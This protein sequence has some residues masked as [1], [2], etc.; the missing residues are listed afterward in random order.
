MKFFHPL[1]I[2]SF[3]L[4]SVVLTSCDKTN[5]L[6]QREKILEDVA[7]IKRTLSTDDSLKIYFL[8]K[9]CDYSGGFDRLIEIENKRENNYVLKEYLNKEA[10]QKSTDSLFREAK[11]EGFTYRDLLIEIDTLIKVK[12]QYEDEYQV[13]YKKIDSICLQVQKIIDVKETL[14]AK[15]SDSIKKSISLKLLSIGKNEYSDDIEV[16]ILIK[17]QFQKPINALSFD[18][19]LTDK[20]GATVAILSC[21][22]NETVIKN[23]VGTWSFEKYGDDRETYNGLENVEAHHVTVNYTITKVNIGGKIIGVDNPLLNL[24]ENL[25]YHYNAKYIS[26]KNLIGHC[27]Y[28]N[29]DHP[30][31]LELKKLNDK[32]SKVRD[33]KKLPIVDLIGQLTIY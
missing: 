8:D 14:N 26:K 4:L 18:A 29:K 21:K 9:L 11:R 16:K 17:N 3:F 33:S 25:K 13:L 32:V 30:L 6:I 5:I 15:R 20:L 10:Y 7:E 22:S 23:Y 28:F 19:I 12:K 31:E 1:Q 27:S 24:G 2:I